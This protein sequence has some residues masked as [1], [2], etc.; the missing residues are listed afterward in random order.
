MAIDE[1][2]ASAPGEATRDLVMRAGARAVGDFPRPEGYGSWTS[3]AIAETV[4]ALFEAKPFLLTEALEAGV[5]DDDALE[6]YVMV[7]LKHHLIDEAKGTDVGRLRRRFVK[8]LGED[9][10]F[11]RSTAAGETW[12]LAEFKGR[13]SSDE[14]EVLRAA[15]ARVRGV[16]IEKLNKGGRT[17]EPVADALRTVAAAVLAAAG[18]TVSA[19]DLARVV[20]ERF[21]P[22]DEA[23]EYIDEPGAEDVADSWQGPD[24][25]VLIDA[26]ARSVFSSLTV[27]EKA[28]LS[29]G[30]AATLTSLRASPSCSAARS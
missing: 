22:G 25:E 5:A 9:N 2:R 1:V 8:V 19:Q 14:L 28:L 30:S 13:T 18:G 16:Y 12:M 4:A 23:L 15:A 26:T 7:A 10:R 27:K 24:F 3:D 29:T 6:A 20:F 21:F 17:R 11:V